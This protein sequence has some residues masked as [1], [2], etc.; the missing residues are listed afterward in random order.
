MKPLLAA[1]AAALFVAPAA[2]PVS[3]EA[4]GVRVGGELVSGAA[5]QVKGLDSTSLLVSGSSVENLGPAVDVSLDAQHA[6]RLD[7]GLRLERAAQGF[8]IRSH[9]PA[10]TLEAAGAVLQ[11]SGAVPF[12]LTPSGFDFGSLGALEGLT[13]A[14]KAEA[15]QQDV[16]SP[17][18]DVLRT[19]QGRA[20]IRSRVFKGSN[21]FVPGAAADKQVLLTL[22][23]ISPGG[24]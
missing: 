16:V 11:A 15:A 21:P 9:G 14:V 7:A 3:Y 22:I 2:A 19:R 5:L 24:F 18:R 10:F 23:P 12:T 20:G 6:L 1:V 13:L 4:N 17:E 8:V